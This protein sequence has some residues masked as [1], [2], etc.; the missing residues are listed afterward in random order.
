MSDAVVI[1]GFGVVSPLGL[2]PAELVRRFC[3]GESALR[4]LTGMGVDDACGAVV[5][6]IPLDL[7]PADARSRSGRLDRLCRL[8]LS[9]SCLAAEAA[10]IDIAAADADRVALSFGTGL[11]CVL[12]DGE[13][14]QKIVES[15]PS[16]ASP[17]LFAYTVSSAAAGEVSIALG[18]KGANVTMH[19]GL[20]AGLQAVGYGFDL[21][22]AG[23]ADIV[24]A[25]G[26][27]ALGPALVTGLD[28]MGLLKREP[29]L[30]FR[31]AA[32]G[33]LPAEAAAVTVLESA[34]C[35]RRRGARPWARIAGYAAGFEPTLTGR[36]GCPAGIQATM[37]RA[38]AA[39]GCSRADVDLVVTSAHGT[40]I[41]ALECAALAAACGMSPG[42]VLLAPKR[43]WGEC[44]GAHGPLSLALAAALL[45]EPPPALADGVAF[46]IDGAPARPAADAALRLRHADVAMVH[47]LCYSGNTVALLVAREG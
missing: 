32:P 6:E 22:R 11:G 44:G 45:R 37:E 7:L 2:S 14:N 35:A 39:S 5:P 43:A 21:I 1:T 20:A 34:V 47:S 24:L 15:G 4:R 25:G 17:R 3:H 10:R 13:Y 16:A 9:A 31:N 28:D 23:K 18:V 36:E 33:I 19:A 30:P 27:D 26:A 40:P 12:T 29:A 8:F 41:D 46:E 42:P 38:L